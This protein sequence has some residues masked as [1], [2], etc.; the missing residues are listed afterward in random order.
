MIAGVAAEQ[1]EGDHLAGVRID[2][3]VEPIAAQ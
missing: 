2:R 1:D 3:E